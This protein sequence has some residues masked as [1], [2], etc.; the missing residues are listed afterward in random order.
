MFNFYIQYILHSVGLRFCV[1]YHCI[2][3]FL[4]VCYL[5]I[6]KVFIKFL[7]FLLSI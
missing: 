7:F 5:A 1:L 4:F 6:Q 3:T 2:I